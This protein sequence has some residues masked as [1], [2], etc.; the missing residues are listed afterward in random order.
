MMLKSNA[1]ELASTAHRIGA[2]LIRGTVRYSGCE[3]VF[4]KATIMNQI[5]RVSAVSN[6]RFRDAA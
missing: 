6:T 3:G 1:A 4:D 5:G 2:E